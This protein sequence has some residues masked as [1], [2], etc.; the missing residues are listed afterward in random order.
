[1]KIYLDTNIID[2][3]ASKTYPEQ[4]WT[5]LN[6]LIESTQKQICTSSLTLV[7]LK[8]NKD[9]Q[10]AEIGINRYELLSKIPL[11]DDW[12]RPPSRFGI[13]KFGR[14][15]SGDGVGVLDQL[16]IKLGTIFYDR[17]DCKH[18]QS[19][20]HN[21]CSHFLTNDKHSILNILKYNLSEKQLFDLNSIIQII[22]LQEFLDIES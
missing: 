22:D 13:A 1:M 3:R 11:S 10:M 17:E 15:G 2:H 5:K 20:I 21:Q 9:V 6:L 16:L 7:E 14:S 12:L 8:N 19:A 18:L 4:F